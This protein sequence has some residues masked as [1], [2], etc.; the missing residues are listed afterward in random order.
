MSKWSKIVAEA[1]PVKQLYRCPTIEQLQ[2]L[3]ILN[4]A[5]RVQAFPQSWQTIYLI[6]LGELARF[7]TCWFTTLEEVV[8]C[9]ISPACE[10]LSE[11]R[12]QNQEFYDKMFK[13]SQTVWNL[14]FCVQGIGAQ[15]VVPTRKKKKWF[16]PSSSLPT[17][18]KDGI[19]RHT[20]YR[21]TQLVNS[22]IRE[23]RPENFKHH[24]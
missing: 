8:P 21:R 16:C 19:G 22:S 14:L 7:C 20:T 5:K 23:R 3:T 15:N 9:A 24:H 6:Y 1:V 11:Y 4:N 10:K 12:R 18:A 17:W 13:K 2:N